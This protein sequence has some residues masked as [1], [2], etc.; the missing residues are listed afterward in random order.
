[1]LKRLTTKSKATI[2]KRVDKLNLPLREALQFDV[3]LDNAEF[4]ADLIETQPKFLNLYPA[5]NVNWKRLKAQL[6]A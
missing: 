2:L 4:V 3:D 5:S 1:M 6:A